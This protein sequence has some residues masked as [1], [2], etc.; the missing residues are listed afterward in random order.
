M[1]SIA[2]YDVAA[3]VIHHTPKKAHYLTGRR[4]LLWFFYFIL[5]IY[6]LIFA[7]LRQ[8]LHTFRPPWWN[9]IHYVMYWPN[10]FICSFETAFPLLDPLNALFLSCDPGCR[11]VTKPVTLSDCWSKKIKNGNKINILRTVLILQL[12]SLGSIR[13]QFP[14]YYIRPMQL[15]PFSSAPMPH[16]PSGWSCHMVVMLYIQTASKTVIISL[17]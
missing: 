4:K 15:S 1:K 11:I 17:L 3:N 13:I 10:S 2:S 7:T 8:T 14:R 16:V 6:W 9:D 5:F 12:K